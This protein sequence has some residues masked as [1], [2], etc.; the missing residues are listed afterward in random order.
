MSVVLR[1]LKAIWIAGLL[2]VSWVQAMPVA[3][4]PGASLLVAEGLES[5]VEVDEVARL[6]RDRFV[7]H[8]PRRSYPI[9]LEHPL[10]LSLKLPPAAS[11]TLPPLQL[12][13]PNALI[14]RYEV[15]QRDANGAWVMSAAGDRVPHTTW[16]LDSLHPRFELFSNADGTRQVY[17]RIIHQLPSSLQ[18]QLLSERE[19]MKSDGIHLLWTGL[20]AG[21]VITLVLT[22]AQMWLAYRD[23]T[24]AWYALY[25][26]GTLLAA[27]SYSGVTQSW[28]WPQA[29]KFASDAVVYGVMSALAFNLQFSRAM[30]G[31][32]QGRAYHV[33]VQTLFALCIGY[34]ILTIFIAR[35]DRIVPIFSALSATV[36]VFVLF[37]ALSAWRKGVR[38]ARYWLLV[39]APYLLAISLA[40]ANS[41][42]V[43]AVPWLPLETPL[44]AAVAEAIAMML[45][46]NA[47]SR[48]KH[49]QTVQQ[50]VTALHDPLT[51][52]LKASS[53][54]EE[55]DKLWQLARLQRRDVAVAYITVEPATSEATPDYEA[56]MTRSVRMVRSIAREFDTVGR[57]SRNRLALLMA[58][59]PQGE[60]LSGRLA[61]LVALGMM[62]ETHETRETTIRF[63]ISVGFRK[64]FAGSFAD[65]DTALLDLLQQETTNPK[66]IHYLAAAAKHRYPR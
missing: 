21:V 44:L 18:P 60:A 35:Y 48:L 23:L 9:S 64:E 56:L 53:F 42:G 2:W 52:F 33:T 26:L 63:R 39:Y 1:G 13:L 40:L 49:A 14:D 46:I 57:L 62:Y 16:P 41:I 37:T 11:P 59:M 12:E 30:F 50:Q 28:A 34:M 20:L 19:A 3:Q 10:W 32:L 65:L 5:S 66:P 38:F 22:C 43:I 47:Y 24:Y 29:S 45:C 58:D 55:A 27:L 6:P 17:I 54:H 61:R 15:Y 31:S 25:L 51:G 36:F 8:E 7:A 4:W